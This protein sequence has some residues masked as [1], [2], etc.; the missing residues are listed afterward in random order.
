M[1]NKII[2]LLLTLISGV[3]QAAH[4]SDRAIYMT[5]IR[6]AS[7]TAVW[8]FPL[9][10]P[11]ASRVLITNADQEPISSS[12]TSTT[13]AYLD[14]TS[15]VQTQLD[16]KQA[17]PL[18]GD[19]TTSGAAATIAANAVTSAKILDGEIVNADINASAA[20]V[21]TKLATISTAS[22]VSNSATTATSANTA[23]AIVARDG[24]GNFAANAITA[25][26][27]TGTGTLALAAGGSNTDVTLTPN[28]TGSV[29][30]VGS[31]GAS[32]VST[33]NMDISTGTINFA[34]GN[35]QRLTGTMTNGSTPPTVTALTTSNMV[36]G[37]VYTVIID[38]TTVRLYSFSGC[39][40][41]KYVPANAITIASSA[42]V[43][44]ILKVATNTCYISWITGF[45]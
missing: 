28:G 15:S 1:K 39:S 14:A 37:G 29:K 18:T 10:L 26:S 42:T 31:F 9:S 32:T 12:V 7:G 24:S 11:T 23:S 22:K 34:T 8:Y 40:T 33:N 36:D 2:I 5:D 30:A 19:V 13:L 17:G 41:A 4:S 20:I 38:D 16:G 35:V 27:V 6:N 21:D 45:L 44:T 25:V 3:A 43:Y